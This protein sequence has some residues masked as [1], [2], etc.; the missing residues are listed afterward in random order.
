MSIIKAT[1]I[2]IIATLMLTY[3]FGASVTYWFTGSYEPYNNFV[4]HVSQ[5]NKTAL[6]SIIMVFIALFVALLLFGAL[7]A[8]VLTIFVV[9]ALAILGVFWPVLLVAVVIY[10]LCR[11]PKALPRQEYIS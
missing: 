1:L 5:V 8:V 7:L 9:I 4:E 6:L 2:A 10:L 3:F 11:K